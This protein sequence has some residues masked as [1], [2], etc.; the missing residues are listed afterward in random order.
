MKKYQIT[1][2][3]EVFDGSSFEGIID[4]GM[5]VYLKKTIFLSGIISPINNENEKEYWQQAKGKLQYYLRNAVDLNVYIDIEEYR[6]DYVYGI[7]YTNESDESLN[8]NMFLKGYVWDNGI[9]LPTDNNKKR[10]T[11]VLNTP[12]ERL[13]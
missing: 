7:V 9:V 10:E 11:Y 4:L 13:K 3:L 5:G 2:V 1:R 8:W 6:D 12:K